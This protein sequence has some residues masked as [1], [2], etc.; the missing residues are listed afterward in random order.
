MKMQT[1]EVINNSIN[2][3]E[4]TINVHKNGVRMTLAGFLI[5][6][7]IVVS[8]IFVIYHN[9]NNIQNDVESLKSEIHND[10]YQISKNNNAILN[11]YI[12][13]HNPKFNELLVR[14]YF[15]QELM[16][17]VASEKGNFISVSDFNN[18]EKFSEGLRFSVNGTDFDAI[19]QLLKTMNKQQFKNTLGSSI[20]YIHT[21][22]ELFINSIADI[23]DYNYVDF[24][25]A[26]GNDD[27]IN[28]ESK[29]KTDI[30]STAV[31][32]ETVYVMC[33]LFIV[34]FAI[35]VSVYKFHHN[36]ISKGYRHKVDLQKIKI[37]ISSCLDESIEKE[38]SMSLI[39]N[40]YS[41][42]HD[43][44]SPNDEVSGHVLADI[45]LSLFQKIPKK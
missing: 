3:L 29:L 44:K 20:D 27:Y 21:L 36:E 9:Q 26:T 8:A 30:S 15:I 37:A 33:S 7:S 31:K 2:E 39:A 40:S 11:K 12:E 17:Q 25:L 28:S 42:V 13:N 6:F 32:V 18:L 16:D 45:M 4:N 5:L 22:D 10:V 23:E 38:Y 34:C 1:I 24:N 43:D 41:T 14:S 35:L 19:K